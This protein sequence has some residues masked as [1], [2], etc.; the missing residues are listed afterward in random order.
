LSNV[1][2]LFNWALAQDRIDRSPAAGVEAPSVEVSRDRVLT[3]DELATIWA[4][5]DKLSTA[6]GAVIKV[7]MLTG[8]RRNGSRRA[9]TVGAV[10]RWFDLELAVR[11]IKE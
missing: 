3:N 10:G 4:G 2:R 7:M 1:R 9:A 8:G 6:H 11:P 5:C